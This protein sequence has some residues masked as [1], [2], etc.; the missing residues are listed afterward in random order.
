MKR[1]VAAPGGEARFSFRM[2]EN[3]PV[4]KWNLRVT[5]VMSGETVNQ[6]FSLR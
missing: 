1:N 2:A 5:D 4:G 6:S 3:D